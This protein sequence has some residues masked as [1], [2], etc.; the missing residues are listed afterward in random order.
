MH[1]LFKGV[2]IFFGLALA[3]CSPLAQCPTP[4]REQSQQAEQALADFA[5]DLF[6]NVS[7][8]DESKNEALSP[9]SIA[10]GL[11]LL[12][13]G[14]DGKTRQELKRSLLEISSS[15][16]DVLAVYRQLEDQLKIDDGKTKLT[17]ANGLFQDKELK[18]ND[19]FVQTLKQCYHVDQQQ[20]D[21]KNQLDQSRQKINQFVAQK[22]SQKI[23]ELFKRDDLKSQDR[24]V[25]ANA[26]YFKAAWKT[27]FNKQ[28]TKQDTF[29]RN[30]KDQ[31]KQQVPFMQQEI[32]LRH[33]TQQDLDA[34]ELPYEHPQLAMYVV[35]PKARDGL[36][37]LEKKLTGKQLRDIISRL[38]QKQVKVQLPKFQ[39]RSPVDLKT[40]LSKMGL[41]ALFGNSADFSRMS[42]TPL[43]VDGG[44]HEAFINTDENGTEGA[45]ATG[46]SIENR[47][48]VLPSQEFKADHP[49]LY[50]VVH[51]QTGAIVFLGKVNSIE[52]HQE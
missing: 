30:G 44:V 19:Q 35:L 31:D 39:V 46:Y 23:T 16:E 15:T 1:S 5:V 17:L 45:A 25:L 9:V 41:D 13:S 24:L 8:K 47:M 4:S 52:Q 6:K 36:R 29:Y 43:K 37:D 50:T 40:T 51:K 33:V 7:S 32:N 34:L 11:A 12:E 26:V 18:L 20:L 2:F 38:Q 27:S 22:T 21:F 10:L 48:V 14:A 28:Q 42:D 3:T 49:F